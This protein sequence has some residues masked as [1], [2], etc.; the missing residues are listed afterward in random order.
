MTDPGRLNQ[1]KPPLFFVAPK[2]PGVP[3]RVPCA[4]CGEFDLRVVRPGHGLVYLGCARCGADG[5]L[6]RGLA[7][8][9]ELY[10]NRKGPK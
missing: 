8:A 7:D 10:Q 3:D 5:P 9:V 1:N 2:E 4:F 6:A